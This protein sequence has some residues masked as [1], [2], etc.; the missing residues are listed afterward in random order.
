MRGLTPA[1]IMVAALLA[2]LAGI[3]GGG[4][5]PA[6][7]LLLLFMG[8][9]YLSVRLTRGRPLRQRAALAALAFAVPLLLAILVFGR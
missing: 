2:V 4:N 9:L 5:P 3:V 6:G 8:G 1:D 7:L